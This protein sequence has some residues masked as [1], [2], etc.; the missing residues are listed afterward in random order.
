MFHGVRVGGAEQLNVAFS[1]G[2]GRK[3]SQPAEPMKSGGGTG[4]GRLTFDV[5]R[6]RVEKSTSINWDRFARLCI[7]TNFI[8]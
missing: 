3:K 1:W 6:T 2:F 5:R 8:S 7:A 4:V